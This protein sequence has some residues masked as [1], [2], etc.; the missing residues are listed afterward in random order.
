MGLKKYHAKRDFS[1]TTEPKGKVTH[2][3]KN[4]FVIQKHAASHLHYDFR[5]ELEGV[6]K[7]WAVPKGPCLDPSVKRLSIHVEDHPIDY[8][9]F[10]GIIPKGEYG[11][12][13]VML[14]DEGIW[15]PEDKNPLAAYHK[16]YLTFTLKAKKLKGR[17]SLIKFKKD[18]DKSWFLIKSKDKYARPLK[19]FDITVA[20]PNSVLSG[21]SL[22][23]I[24]EDYSAI[25]TQQGL[26]KSKAPKLELPIAA[27]PKKIQ[28]QLATLV[29]EPP[30]GKEW[31]HEIK[32]DGY[33][34]LAFINKGKVKLL[35][36][37]Q[38]DWTNKFN[39]VV[40]ELS[41]LKSN[42]ILDGEIVLLDKNNKSDFQTLQN[43]LDDNKEHPYVYYIFDLLYFDQ[44]NLTSLPLKKRKELLR[45]ILPKNNATLQFSD[46]IPGSGK[47]TFKNACRL[48][49][50]GIISKNS[51]DPYEEKR[52]K[53]WLKIKCVKRQEFVI[54]GYT[55]PKNSRAHFGS[56][57]LGVFDKHKN[58]KFAGNV[59]TGFNTASL[60]TIYDLLQKIKTDKNPFTTRPPGVT[61]AIWVKP[62]LIA[63]IEFT[64]LTADGRV[65][66]P[67]F[68]G[69]REDKD[70]KTVSYE[71][72]T[73]VKSKTILT[74]PNKIVFPEDQISKQ[75]IADYYS[76]IKD[77]ILPHIINRPLT[78]VRCPDGYKKCFYQKHLTEN[79]PKHLFSFDK[80][81][82]IK[83]FSGLMELVQMR[84]LEIHP[85]AALI[86]DIE[87][88]NFITFD[89]DPA[90][91]VKW[92]D[93]VKAALS[94]RDYLLEYKLKSF[95]KTTGGKGL[96][97][98]VPI[99]PIYSWHIVKEFAHAFVKYLVLEN[100]TKYIDQMSKAKRK[101]KIF[102]DYLRNGRGATS[103]AAYSIRARLHAPVSTPLEWDELTNTF[104]D[105]FF[106]LKTLPDRLEQLKEDP[107]KDI[108]K[109]KQSLK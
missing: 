76:T 105:T 97:I 38:K 72:P 6:L 98:V 54:G 11:G 7:S 1:K 95:V 66:H 90:P 2:S 9:K 33:R 73:P 69:L 61:T 65:R 84:T 80:N 62:K 75:D 24:T 91:D 35:S 23:E 58:L 19:E 96:H 5:I 31:F 14:W 60:K 22:Q 77:W 101:G 12:G 20:K 108:Y 63:E 30:N 13:T 32:F 29:N 42:L 49:L 70:P 78:L 71:K 25:W 94:I 46:H 36:R 86:K 17:F 64:E 56:L 8:G 28:P 16:G 107:W 34:M 59:G 68:K 99:K 52:T 67:S 103:V 48:G 47:Q 37:N 104:D 89:L 26:K 93:T 57:F 51:N 10:E 83:N 55:P 3:Q 109:L 81:I 40:K 39:N 27:F 102:I 74:N 88:P 21:E 15:V 4:L 100:P 87:H 43:S 50:E 79:M 45:N 41:K 18:D 92:K 82:Y 53:S 44:Y 106:T 85:W